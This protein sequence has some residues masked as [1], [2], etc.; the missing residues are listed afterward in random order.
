MA[1][2]K[3]LEEASFEEIQS[4]LCQDDGVAQQHLDA[5]RPIYYMEADDTYVRKEYPD[6]SMEFV[7]FINGKEILIE[8]I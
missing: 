8:K 7:D 1:Q 5:G 6:G 2:T 4:W 3:Y